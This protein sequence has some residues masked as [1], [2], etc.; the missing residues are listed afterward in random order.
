MLGRGLVGM[1]RQPLRALKAAPT[2]LPHLDDVAT[3]RHVPGVKAIARSS[4][5][6]KRR[7]ASAATADPPCRAT[8]SSRPQT[9]F[10]TR[11]SA[12][13]RV[14]FESMSLDDVKMI[15][16]TFGCTVN[17]VVL[18]ICAAGLR[19]WLDERGEL[20]AEP[21]LG[22][23]PVSV[24]TPEQ[25]GTFGNRVSVMITELPTETADPVQRLRRIN[26][27]MKSA[28]DRHKALP[29]SLMQDAN[30]FI[31]PALFA[32]AGRATSRLAGIRGIDQP[33]NVAISNVPVPRRRC[34]SAAHASARSTRSPGCST[35]SA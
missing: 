6:V 9:R 29:A 26:E 20:P 7:P 8:T 5:L 16:N 12:H 1:W 11:I 24:R 32:Q 13:R 21:L 30:H 10:Q 19:S 33:V 18:A 14:A 17:D 3:L 4:R 23:I 34:T 2:T 25:M 28:K 22:F 27:T 31:P 15:K 35:G